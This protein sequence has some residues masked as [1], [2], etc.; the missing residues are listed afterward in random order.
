[1]IEQ[2]ILREVV[3]SSATLQAVAAKISELHVILQ[4]ATT[5]FGI[6]VEPPAPPTVVPG[7]EQPIPTPPP[8]RAP[9]RP[10][11]E[12]AATVTATRLRRWTPRAPINPDDLP[13]V[14]EFVTESRG[15]LEAAEAEIL[16]LEEAPDNLE[17]INAVFRSFHTIKGVAGFLNF[18]QIGGARALGENLLD[19]ARHGNLQLSG[20]SVD[21]VLEP[22][23]S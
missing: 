6:E 17:A 23:T 21:A 2:I 8:L 16:K 14:L 4:C 1:M 18:R 9:S 22:W 11:W 12:T 20:P 3:D 10:L 13:L 19:L 15:H 5:D 7:F